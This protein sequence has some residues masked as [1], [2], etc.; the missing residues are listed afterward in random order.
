MDVIIDDG[1]HY[2]LANQKTLLLFWPYVRPGGFYVI[3]DVT[4][5]ARARTGR[6]GCRAAR[7]DHGAH[8]EKCGFAPSG[9]SELAHNVTFLLPEARA[10][11][12]ENTAFFADTLVGHRAFDEFRS[13]MGVTWMQGRVNHNS[14]MLVIRR[15]TNPR[16]KLAQVHY[17]H[18]AMPHFG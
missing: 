1:D 18:V 5:G 14:H 10:I 16:P 3:E 2:H 6:Y 7:R 17:G 11:L 13:A 15:R 12:E 9:W 4:T 8:P